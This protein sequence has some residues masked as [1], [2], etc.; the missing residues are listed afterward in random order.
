MRGNEAQV[1]APDGVSAR[2]FLQRCGVS[3]H[4][5]D[6]YWATI[7]M[8]ILNVPLERCSAGALM[9]FFRVLLGRNDIRMGFPGVALADLFVPALAAR[10]HRPARNRRCGRTP[11][12]SRRR[13]RA[14]RSGSPT[15][16]ATPRAFV[17]RRCRRRICARCCRPRGWQAARCPQLDAFAPSEYVARICG[18]RTSSRTHARGRAPGRRPRSITTFTISRTSAPTGRRA[19]R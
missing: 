5:I 1:L 15:V 11:S 7:S 4:L 13:E 3:A 14:L 10:W 17:S 8:T 18:L 9:R 12:H 6:T 2:D 16:A 19:R